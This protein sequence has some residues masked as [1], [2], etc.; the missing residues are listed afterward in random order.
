M[1][2]SILGV[3]V[4]LVAEQ[5]ALEVLGS[6]LLVIALFPVVVLATGAEYLLALSLFPALAG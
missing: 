1:V 2:H 6:S 5:L 3:L 4:G